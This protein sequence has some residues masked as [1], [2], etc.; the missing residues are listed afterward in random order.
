MLFKKKYPDMPNAKGIPYTGLAN[1]RPETKAI[2][3]RVK[4]TI[5]AMPFD[6]NEY[7]EFDVPGSDGVGDWGR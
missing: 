4:D 2:A 7:L 1:A 6:V 3:Q 5:D